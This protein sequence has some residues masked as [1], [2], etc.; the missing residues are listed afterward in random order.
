MREP[1]RAKEYHLQRLSI[2][3]QRGNVVAMLGTVGRRGEWD[4]LGVTAVCMHVHDG[5]HRYI[6]L[7]L[8]LF[9]SNIYNVNFA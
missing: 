1:K 9:P 2:A 5:D 8:S 3:I 6:F 4:P 7:H